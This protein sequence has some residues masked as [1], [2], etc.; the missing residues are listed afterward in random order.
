MAD[1]IETEALD[2]DSGNVNE[3]QGECVANGK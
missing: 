2:V 1:F 3:E